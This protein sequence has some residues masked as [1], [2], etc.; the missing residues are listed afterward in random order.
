MEKYDVVYVLANDIKSDEIRYSVRSVVKNFPYNRIVFYGGKPKDIEPDV[1]VE[2]K[3]VGYDRYDKVIYTLEK[4]C[5]DDNLT[6]NFWL[7][8]DDFFIMQ[9][10]DDL[11]YAFAGTIEYRI[12]NL[13]FNHGPTGSYIRAQKGIKDYL[14]RH[15]Y[16]TLNYALHMPMLI[17][18][19][20]A[21]K[22]LEEHPN[23]KMFRSLYGNVNKVGG[24][25]M[26]DVK[27][28][29]SGD[30]PD[31]NSPLLS[32]KDSSFRYGLVGEYIRDIFKEPCK[33][34]RDNRQWQQD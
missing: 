10:V 3:Q 29:N 5:A 24:I 9:P 4:I 23:Q 33:Y 34:E 32:T 22:T 6:D 8:N 25:Q 21:S 1:Y 13:D 7:F 11:S 31:K 19:K 17:N 28:Y 16:D 27:I 26:D 12:N 14:V 20:L 30:E 18:R 2:V 15:G